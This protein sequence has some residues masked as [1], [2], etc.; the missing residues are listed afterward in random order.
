MDEFIPT[1]NPIV[2]QSI[3]IEKNEIEILFTGLNLMTS[4]PN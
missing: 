3:P 4:L 1:I 2:K